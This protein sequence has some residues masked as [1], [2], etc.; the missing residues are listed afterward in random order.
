MNPT[1][2]KLS[3]A[4]SI[5]TR[6]SFKPAQRAGRDALDAVGDEPGRTDQQQ[7][8]GKP[9]RLAGSRGCIAEEQQRND[10]AE[11]DDDQASARP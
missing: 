6:V 8:R 10:I 4:Y 7:R 1:S 9:R 5:G 11:H 3:A 2:Q